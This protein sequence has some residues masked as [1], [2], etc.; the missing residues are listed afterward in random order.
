MSRE[1]VSILGSARREEVRRLRDEQER[2]RVNPLLYL[3]SPQVRVSEPSSK[4]AQSRP[5]RVGWRKW[6]E[7]EFTKI[8]LFPSMRSPKK[9]LNPA[10]DDRMNRLGKVHQSLPSLFS[11]QVDGFY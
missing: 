4:I 9:K 2:L 3:V 5:T 8:G 7:F 6:I 1:E 10:Y 11:L